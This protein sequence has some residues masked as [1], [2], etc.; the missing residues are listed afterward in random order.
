[1]KTKQTNFLLVVA[2]FHGFRKYRDLLFEVHGAGDIIVQPLRV[3]DQAVVVEPRIWP[4]F[5]EVKVVSDNIP[6]IRFR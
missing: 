1:M 4:I 6:E 2:I 3:L 5:I